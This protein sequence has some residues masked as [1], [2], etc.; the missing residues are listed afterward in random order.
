MRPGAREGWALVDAVQLC[1]GG[2]LESA[3]RRLLERWELVGE[4]PTTLNLPTLLDVD[5]GAARTGT[6]ALVNAPL[7]LLRPKPRGK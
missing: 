1:Q 4:Y 3:S 6:S 2:D 5:P 7:L